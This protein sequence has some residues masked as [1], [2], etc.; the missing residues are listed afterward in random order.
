M[1]DWNWTSMNEEEFDALLE[2]SAHSL[3]PDDDTVREITPW[4]QAMN[5]ILCGMAMTTVTLN[6]LKL[7][8]LLPTIGL[9]LVLLGFRALRRENRW[10][11]ACWVITLIRAVYIGFTLIANATIYQSQLYAS[12]WMSWLS[13]I[14]IALIFLLFFCL[15]GALRTV[16]QK[17][18]LPPRAAGATAMLLWYAVLCMLALLQYS[19]IVIS[20]LM[21][22]AYFLIIRSLM[23]LSRALDEAGYTIGPASVRISDRALALALGGVLL[24]GIVC[25]YLFANHYPMDWSPVDAAEHSRVEEIKTELL[26]LGFPEYVL[27][28]LSPEDIAACE[29]ALRV[30]YDSH[31]Y[32]FNEGHMEYVYDESVFEF[33]EDGYI[34][35]TVYDVNELLITGV[36]VQLPGEREQW[37]IFQHFLWQVDPGF[38]GTESIQLWPAYRSY[39]GWDA[40]SGFS[41]RVLYDRD[42][43]SYTAPYHFLDKQSYISDS[44]F[45][46]KR[47]NTDVFAAFSL[48]KRGE[49]HRGYVS[50]AI[51]EMNDGYIVDAWI[52][53]THQKGRLQYPVQTAMDMRMSG[54]WSRSGVFL[55]KQDALQFYPTEEDARLLD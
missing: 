2:E 30:I 45:W 28:D 37:K 55:T 44:V 29:G 8:Y 49:Q 3:P 39:E 33:R 7:N 43:T 54:G 25:G 15:R 26:A 31:E 16:Q 5:R 40:A 19:G 4:R 27:N 34:W 12:P 48:P 6:F 51:K 9:F 22:V 41:G 21:I 35:K 13:G 23:R 14:N 50:Y 10:F 36:A 52:N 17:A 46:G 20:L 11:R 42:G 32:P 18:G 38:Y 1:N 47:N 24:L 53:Y